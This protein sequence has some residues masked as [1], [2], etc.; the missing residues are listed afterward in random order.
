LNKGVLASGIV[1]ILIAI[2]IGAL[3]LWKGWTLGGHHS[4]VYAIVGIIGLIGVILAAW[5]YMMK[6]KMQKQEQ[7]Q[8][9][10]E[11]AKQ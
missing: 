1:L 6:P 7:K 9:Q 8:E 3:E 11:T 10:T 4:Y 5:S 2:I